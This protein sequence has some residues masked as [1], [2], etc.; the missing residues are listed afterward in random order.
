MLYALLGLVRLPEL[1]QN[2]AFNE[3]IFGLGERKTHVSEGAG[4]TYYCS[5]RLCLWKIT[6]L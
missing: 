2:V 3:E 1:F 4:Q 6:L 5:C